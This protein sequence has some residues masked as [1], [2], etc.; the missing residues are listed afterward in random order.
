MTQAQRITREDIET[1]LREIDSG[2]RQ[3]VADKKRTVLTGVAVGGA[4]IL[5]VMFLLWR[6]SGKKKTTIVEIRRV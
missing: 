1:K 3:Q 5:F 4:V 6:R 2:F